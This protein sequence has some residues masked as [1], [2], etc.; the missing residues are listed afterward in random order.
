MNIQPIVTTTIDG[1]ELRIG[2]RWPKLNSNLQITVVSQCVGL[3][4]DRFVG[5][6]E[7]AGQTL[8]QTAEFP[9]KRQAEAEAEQQL[10]GRVVELLADSE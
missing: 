1:R 7:L 2:Q 5:G 4:P 10:V 6:V 9:D 3:S 8:F